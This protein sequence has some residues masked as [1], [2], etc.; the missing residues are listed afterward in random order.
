ML[1][2][3][4][5]DLCPQDKFWCTRFFYY[6]V[7]GYD[8]CVRKIHQLSVFKS[9]CKKWFQR[10]PLQF[11]S[12]DWEIQSRIGNTGKICEGT[13]GE[14]ERRTDK[15]ME[16]RWAGWGTEKEEGYNERGRGIRYKSV[17]IVLGYP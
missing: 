1:I 12:K 9:V 14:F 11:C 3:D 8:S 16:N 13:V 4:L 5:L 2:S 17:H 6:R 7:S 15:G 10:P